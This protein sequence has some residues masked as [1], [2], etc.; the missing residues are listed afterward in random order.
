MPPEY[1]LGLSIRGKDYEYDGSD[2]ALPHAPYPM[3]GMG[4]FTHTDARDRPAEIFAG[5]TTLHFSAQQA[6]YL[7][8][9]IIPDRSQG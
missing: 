7:V 4:P 9:P 1:R 5:V 2:A 8:L 3:K 6:P